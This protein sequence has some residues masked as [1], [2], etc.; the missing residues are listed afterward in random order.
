VYNNSNN[1]DHVYGAVIVALPLRECSMSADLCIKLVDMIH[2]SAY[3][4]ATIVLHLPSPFITAQPE[5]W[6]TFYYPTE[7]RRLSR[8]GW[9]VKYRCICIF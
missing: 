2:R 6:Y 8:H 7:G 4:L 9:P 3:K 1:H 5:S